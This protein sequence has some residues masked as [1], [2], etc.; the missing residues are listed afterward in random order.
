MG[1][2]II[3]W[4]QYAATARKAAAE[5]AVLLRNEN[6]ALPLK[7]GDKIAV[8]GRIQTN[9]YKSGTGSGGAVHTRYVVSILDALRSCD[10]LTLNEK[11]LNV[12][13]EWEKTHPFDQGTGWAGEPWCQKEMELEESFV[14]EAAR[15]SDAAVVIIGR[16]AGEDKDNSAEAGSYMLSDVENDM[17]KKV[18][19]AFQR[20][21]VVLNVGNI[22][23][24]KWVEEW[25][26]QAVLYTWQG[27]QEGGNA[28]VDVL[29][30]K[31]NPCGHLPDTIAWDITDYPSTANFGNQQKVIYQE[32]IYM[33]Y[34]YFQTFAPEKVLYPFGYGLSYTEF[35]MKAVDTSYDGSRV[36]LSVE[37]E[38]T[39]KVAGRQVA[40]VYLKKPQGK[41]G[42]PERVLIGFEKTDC[43]QPG[44]KC[45][46]NMEIPVSVMATYDD[47]GVTGFPYAW[48]LE[49]GIYEFYLGENVRDASGI[50]VLTLSETIL[51]EQCEQA[52]APV[53]SYERMRNVDGVIGYEEVP[54]RTYSLRER[55]AAD[56]ART[57]EVVETAGIDESAA[58][59]YTS[60]TGDLGYCLEDVYDGKISMQEF[61]AQLSDED[62]SHLA[63]GE[64]MCS[65]KVTPGTASACGGL[66]ERL[67]EF[68]IPTIC[69]ADGPSGIRMDCGTI[70]FSLPNGTCLASTFDRKV[71]EELFAWE[72]LEMRKNR[73]DTLLGPGINLHRNPLNGRNFEYF[74][75][76]PLLTGQIAAA[77]I[78]GLGIRGVTGTIKHFACNNQETGRFSENSVV[79][80]R[81]LRELYLKSFEIA[82]KEGDAF[83][84]MSSYNAI[85]GIWTAGNYD[86][87]TT[88][89]RKEWGYTGMVMTDWWASANEEGEEA[90]RGGN[91]HAMVRAQNDIFMVVPDTKAYGDNILDSLESGVLTRGE[92]LRNATNICNAAMR[93]PCMDWLLNRIS[94]EEKRDIEQQREADGIPL[95]MEYQD[96]LTNPVLSVENLDT[97]AGSRV[98]FGI[99]AEKI[100]V[101]DLTFEAKVDAGGLA[102][103]PLTIGLD[104]AILDTFTLNGTNEEWIPLH[105]DK[106]VITS[107]YHYISLFFAQTGM[108]IRNMQLKLVRTFTNEEFQKMMVEHAQ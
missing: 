44:E 15:E 34:R 10:S 16:T 75:E 66:T 12:Y 56:P 8:F 63:K 7:N 102:Q 36:K 32:D 17:L 87:L 88:I 42:Q 108:Q 1:K 43:L 67:Q 106:I 14:V 76:D 22:I 33:G 30:G 9:Y 39:G 11:V 20:V 83:S 3:D 96:V 81:A 45:I 95:T 103:V 58:D 84:I 90:K 61:L 2:Y 78:R 40:Q 77:Q 70:A 104:S 46:L 69:C 26:P 41:L 73:V 98:V 38:N 68:G 71:N 49:S 27:G 74:S 48:V 85:N 52:L 105:R 97:S 59:T 80:E 6:Q 51:I 94:D 5:G 31:V 50:Y 107:P 62:L 4:D 23:D 24:M 65:P 91:L 100:S 21:I 72:G 18:C 89:L 53:E 86:L 25:K 99:V 93:L 60:Y 92:L 28:V 19:G 54:V 13:Q 55:M 29:T 101:F 35:Q 82:V 37:V 64:G 79:S 57:A 47:S